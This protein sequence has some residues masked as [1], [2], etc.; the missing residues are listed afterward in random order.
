MELTKFIVQ[1]WPRFV[2]GLRLVPRSVAKSEEKAG[3]ELDQQNCCN[4][5]QNSVIE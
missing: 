1:F 5:K 4:T 3:P 2:F